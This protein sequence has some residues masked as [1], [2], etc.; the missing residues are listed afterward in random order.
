[1][2]A[3]ELYLKNQ[4][5]TDEITKTKVPIKKI[6]VKTSSVIT[7]QI[8]TKSLEEYGDEPTQKDFF[9]ETLSMP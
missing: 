4:E 2:L 7:F 6:F 5:N 1:M 9:R 8:D 3:Y